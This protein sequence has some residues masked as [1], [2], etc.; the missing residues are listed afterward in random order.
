[1]KPV[2]QLPGDQTPEPSGDEAEDNE[3]IEDI[4]ELTQRVTASAP[5]C[6]TPS[7]AT[8]DAA[9]VRIFTTKKPKNKGVWKGSSGSSGP[10]QAKR[11]PTTTVST[12]PSSTES[13]DTSSSDDEDHEVEAVQQITVKSKRGYTHYPAYIFDNPP[14]KLKTDTLRKKLMISEIKHSETQ[15]EFYERGIILM[16]HLKEFMRSI[17]MSGVFGEAST[18]TATQNDD[19]GYAIPASD[20]EGANNQPNRD[21]NQWI[22][23]ILGLAK[24]NPIEDPQLCWHWFL[25][26]MYHHSKG[27]LWNLVDPR[28]VG[29]GW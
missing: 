25:E 27:I 4:A 1:M 16:S 14:K 6:A 12:A 20:E 10:P 17:S 22:C 11:K 2:I 8:E 5:V 18:S 29:S 3:P 9:R 13:E 28:I 23:F 24:R 19:H 26:K 7:Q 21:S 15:T